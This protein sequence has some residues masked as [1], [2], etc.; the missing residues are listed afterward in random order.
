M[1]TDIEYAIKDDVTCSLQPPNLWKVVFINDDKTPMDLVIAILMD[2]FNMG[3]EMA[4]DLTM[5]VHELGSAIAGIFP[6][7]IAEQRASDSVKMARL[8][9]APLVVIAEE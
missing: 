4:V 9:G 3:Y 8:N 7:E 5:E 2:I 1:P 6:Y